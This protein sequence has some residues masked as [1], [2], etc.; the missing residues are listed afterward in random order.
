MP[1]ATQAIE[2]ADTKQA[3]T[4][5]TG[6]RLA[7]F[8]VF[9]WGTFD[10]Q[11]W[12]LTP[13][14]S[15]ALLTGNIGSGKSTL[16]D[17]LTTL[18]VPPRKLAF[19]K[20]A[21]AE[22]KERSIESYFFGFYTSQQDEYGKARAVG[23]RHQ[24]KH[25]S[26][27]LAE[28][29]S[30]ALKQSVTLAQVFWLKPGDKKVKR[31]YVVAQQRLT[32]AEHFSHFGSQINQLRKRL[33]KIADLELF[34]AFTPYAQK[35]SQLLG[36]GTDGK[37]L[38]LFNQTI[39]MKSVGSVTDFV[40]DNML[41]QPDV[42]AQL[43][44]LERNYD[45][46]K[47]LHDAVV[48]ARQK[49]ELLTPVDNFGQAVLSAGQDKQH[50]EACRDLTD[51][52]MANI[53]VDLYQTRLASR[54]Q[55][56]TKLDIKLA[57]LNQQ[58][59]SLGATITQLNEDI[60]ENGGGRLQQLEQNIQQLSKIRDDSKRVCQQYL[61]LVNALQLNTALNADTFVDNID[62]AKAQ[63]EALYQQIE[64]VNEQAFSVKQSKQKLEQEQQ[65][66]ATQ[67]A[68]LKQRKSNIHHVNLLTI[69]EHICQQLGVDEECLPFVA[70]LIQVKPE[71]SQWQGAIERV[72]HNFALSL[73]VP[74]AL[75]QEV[76][77]YVEQTHL[78]ARLV[79][80]RIREPENYYPVTRAND[81][82][83]SKI[84]LK[85]D[86]E[87]YNWLDH[88]LAKRFNYTCCTNMQE[89]RRSEKALTRNGQ[90]KSGKFRHEK[91]D[92]HKLHDE[93]RYVL[94]W[95]NKEKLKLL[96]AQY[97]R[98]ELAL[99]KSSS[100]LIELAKTKDQLGEQQYKTRQLA[101]F[102]FSFEQINWS[103]YAQQIEALQREQAQL[104]QSSDVLDSL[105][106]QLAEQQQALSDT[107]SALTQANQNKGSLTEKINTEQQALAS[108][109]A[110]LSE[111]DPQARAHCF[112][113]LDNFYQ[114]YI[115]HQ[116]LRINM[117]DN[118]TSTL[119]KKLNDKIQ[120]LEEKRRKKQAQMI[121]A[122]NTFAHT[123]PNEVT[124]F[125]ASVESLPEY[126][127]LLTRLTEEDLPRHEARFKEMLNRDTIRAMVLFASYLDKQEEEIDARIRLINQSLH[128][129]DYQTGTYIEIDSIA[130]PDVEI[131]DFKQR[132][133]NCYELS[134]DDELY[135]EEK[136]ERVKDLIEQ[137]R[138]EPKWT[139][140]VV[141]VR[142]WHL[143][144]VVE[145]YREDNSEKECY[146]DS[147]GKSGGQKE[148]L[149]YAILAAAIILQYGLVDSQHN[150]NHKNKRR[151]N[152][153]VI[154]EAF[155]RGSK[156]STRFGLELFKKLGLQLLLV[157]PLQ[158]LDVIEHY[159][160]HV[161]FVDQQNNQSMLLNMTIDEYRE[162]VARSKALQG[163]QHLVED[164]SV[165]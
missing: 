67:T 144:N 100:E 33:R 13:A 1:E 4:E 155:A 21:G 120:H 86:S 95:S 139:Q 149:A 61:N 162:Q 48:A 163:Y 63:Q 46:L 42:E 27:I 93:K 94:G 111:C 12:S 11:V 75:Y 20:A 148:K 64:Q 138:N 164:L 104:I 54:Q 119:R 62:C 29:Y 151:F 128:A 156:D 126:K 125:D 152:L 25:Y 102:A 32:I 60:R 122:M 82:L 107:E 158:K 85:S 127:Q 105:Q 10:K 19:N 106:Q 65:E 153:V 88:E 103:V 84:E 110:L 96:A 137:M 5:L 117:L 118:V 43:Q 6:F 28:F 17:G 159:V 165:S 160:K 145:R 2:L 47:R 112:P 55:E 39:S 132:L 15:N 36:L 78:G 18:L 97:N 87:Y 133:K 51:V 24:G 40:R 80:Y 8:S 79:Y 136:F 116:Q 45:D 37:A 121:S 69:R 91:D 14:Q 58:K 115:E 130:S 142:Y 77:D 154:D 59:Q 57:E 41:E 141:D 108:K 146:S 89:F 135:S 16:V 26:V 83:L 34:D 81:S 73:I 76:C 99:K 30:Q 53:A 90:I 161:H 44:E 157:T 35:F 72:L 147:G 49:V 150:S 129:L 143:F 98:F 23:L 66:V 74:E 123:F 68:A 50:I 52:Y 113:T 3:E 92:R 124:E 56:L 114:Q 9:N 31:L 71:Q 134:T 22:E 38:A 101:N 140:K 109:Q 7:N 70:E 131:R